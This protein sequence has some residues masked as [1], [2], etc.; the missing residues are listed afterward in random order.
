MNYV[1]YHKHSCYSN[2]I[3]PDSA[4]QNKD[5]LNRTLELGHT[6]LSSVEHGWTGNFMQVFDLAKANNLKFL[7]GLET[8]FV[9][10]R[11]EKDATNAHLIVLAKNENGR[12]AI[13]DMVSEASITGFYYKP[14]VDLPLLF[15]LPKNDVWLTSACVGGVWK[16]SDD[17]EDLIIQFKNYFGNNYFL[18]TQYHNTDSQKTINARILSL[19]NK[20]NIPIISGCDSHYI[21]AK[22][23]KDRED[24]LLSK[25]IV[26][27]DESNWN[28]DY[29]DS[30]SVIARYEKQGILNKYQIEESINNTL[31]F[32]DVEEYDSV[33]F[34]KEIKMPT[35]YPN[36]SQDEKDDILKTIVWNNFEKEKSNIPVDKYELY[37]QEINKELDII[38]DTKHSDY[39]LLNYEII[40]TAKEMGGIITSSGRGCF[41][42]DALIPTDNGFKK[43]SEITVGDKVIDLNGEFKS[44]KN[45]FQ[46]NVDEDLIEIKY[47][48]GNSKHNSNIC[49]KDHKILIHR[50]D[51]NQWIEAKNILD[52]DM[53]CFPKIK[54]K[55]VEEQYV[56]LNEF[57]IFGYEYDDAY[58][59]EYNPNRLNAYEFSP[60]E[61]A[62]AINV[63]KSM[64]EKYA[65]GNV[66]AFSRKK[67]KELELLEYTGFKN[68]SEY[69]VYIKTKRTYKINRFVKNDTTWNIFLG[70]MYGDGW[71]CS[72]RI[73]I[74]FALNTNN[75]KNILNRQIFENVAKD[76]IGI[77]VYENKSKNK[78]LAQLNISSKILHNYFLNYIFNYDGTTKEK[79]F[80]KNLF[81]QN[82]HNL[83]AIVCGLIITDGSKSKDSNRISFDNTSKSLT[84]AYRL[85][86]NMV[87][88]VPASISVREPHIDSRGF[89][90]K[91]S[92]K[93][94]ASLQEFTK[95]N[96]YIYLPVIGINI[97]KNKN[98]KVYDL[99][100]EDSHSFLVGNMV[101]HNS[102]VS[103]YVNKLLG[104]TQIDRISSPVKMY[105]ERFMSSTRI[106]ESKS[107]ADFDMNL[108][109]PEVFALA[110]KKIL[111]EESSYPM[112][113]FGTLK[114]KAAWK[115]Y[116]RAKNVPFDLANVVSSQIES[117]EMELKHTSE[118]DKDDVN[119]LDYITPEYQTI[120]KESEKYLGIVSDIKIAPCGY[121]LLNENIRKEIGLIRIK[122]QNGTEHICCAIDGLSAEN[123]KFLKNDLLKVAVVELINMV[124][125]RIGKEIDP[126]NKLLEIC[127][128]NDK[129]WNVFKNA[130]TM[131]INQVEQ[132]GTNGRV[133][134]Y[135]PKNIS[136][137]CAFVAA[138][139]P[140]FKSMYKTFENRE[141]FS[142]DIPSFDNL[143]RTPELPQS[144]LLYQEMAMAALNF[145]GIPLSECYDIIKNIAKKRVEKV[146]K[147]KEIFIN[148]FNDIIQKNENKNEKESLELANKVWQILEDSS[149]YQFNACISGATKIQ[150]AG[151]LCN[152]YQPTVEE[153]FKIMNDR[154]YAINTKHSEL[155]AKYSRYGY[156]NAL[157]MYPDQR[158]RKNKIKNIFQSGI[159]AT[160]IITLDNGSNIVCT[161]NHKFPTPAGTKQLSELEIDDELYINNGYE[162]N[163][164]KYK[165]TNGTYESN[166]PKKGQRGFQKMPLG[167][168]ARYELCR[169]N[170]KQSHTGCEICD[171]QYK[172]NIRFELHHKD[173]DRT[174]NEEHNLIWCC[175]PCHKKE[176]YNNNRVKI[177]EKGLLT[178]TR[179]IVSIEYVGEEMT[180]DIEMTAPA[181][182]FISETGL[183]TS[184]SHSYSVAID[185]LYGAYLKSHY[186]LYFYEQFLQQL[187]SNGEKDRIAQTKIEAEKAYK[188]K[189]L[190][191]RFG[192]DNRKIVADLESFGITSS[193]S[194]IKGFS[195][196]I[197]ANMFALGQNKYDSFVEFL[198]DVE[199]NNKFTS[200]IEDLIK[201]NYFE[202][203]GNNQKL[204][205]FYLE[206]T[207]GVNRYSKTHSEKTKEKRIAELKRI[208]D[209]IP[210]KKFPVLMQILS[211]QEILGN[212]QSTYSDLDKRY[213][214]VLQ[215]NEKFSPRV[216]SYCLS[217]GSQST[218]KIQQ[219]TFD[220]NNFLAG[221][222]LYCSSFKKKPAVKFDNGKY[223]N[224]EGEWTWWI[225]SYKVISP[226]EFDKMIERKYKGESIG[227]R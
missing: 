78:N 52:T 198:I 14:R 223:E 10:N 145:A 116:A 50:D 88:E 42:E 185:G 22:Q 23:S 109:N 158:I 51:I 29:P 214:Y 91:K 199:E 36:L 161:L 71:A 141:N 167:N 142:Y 53:V 196:A 61:I 46:Y 173:Q 69:C 162:K 114:P 128:N 129:V 76:Y 181:H 160:Y 186:P 18:E 19:S 32:Q 30:E 66:H 38:I 28:M 187:E 137:L 77:D 8:Y 84:N 96:E 12:K 200:K 87:Y 140:G 130:W 4:V 85:L 75:H 226:D 197:G 122:S 132:K 7:F 143:L 172:D 2:V 104:F 174:N 210:N 195:S 184:N 20:Y 21:F 155:H 95:D 205:E 152:Q 190:P 9:K 55:K 224:I 63:G 73:S 163:L 138:I 39:F 213:V 135:A 217:N 193:L 121:L 194:S 169:E 177:Y 203:F 206:F 218:L 182:N 108:A 225:D 165:L 188:I 98:I 119:V 86:L 220:S 92:Y 115:M 70:M 170:K 154:E 83:E 215:L 56:D 45:T 5:Y 74:G 26:Y 134:K 133:A 44:V 35:I 40:K 68:Q 3:T 139:R 60:S 157:S 164:K 189:F 151:G 183:V 107:L 222:I 27:E 153:M 148:G 16:Y 179:K 6:V 149:K 201:I 118:D 13:N 136:E 175:V 103:F 81:Y 43:I 146:L 171:L 65:N 82:R 123:H 209:A 94:R 212:I 147:Y 89:N 106:L 208:F 125:D 227:T 216:Q 1:N 219:R 58:I 97:I 93:I 67:Y 99:E 192:Q 191:Y 180:Y 34:N 101:V 221:D 90:S 110:Q 168:S 72:D 62:R 202:I 150:K 178:T 131:G 166:C 48:T 120:F 126:V 102:G 33:I 100:V 124:Y 59:Y 105:P 79:E 176:H 144:F 117:Y 24:Y 159:Q 204:H 111:G 156:G 113:A 127:N 57:N 11:F 64:I 211:E 207:K 112:I 31:L 25:N 80:N 54:T 41:T 37:V 49:T 47:I 17:Y 15:S